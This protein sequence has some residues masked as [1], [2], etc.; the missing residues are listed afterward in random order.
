MRKIVFLLL[1]SFN[2]IG[3]S[4]CLQKVVLTRSK[5]LSNEIIR[6]EEKR[7]NTKPFKYGIGILC[8]RVTKINEIRGFIGIRFEIGLNT[9]FHIEGGLE[10]GMGRN[11]WYGVVTLKPDRRYVFTV[12]PG[13]GFGGPEGFILLIGAEIFIV[14]NISFKFEGRI[15]FFPP[16][17]YGASLLGFGFTYFFE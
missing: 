1:I 5:F 14:N 15:S 4:N 12:Y 7:L 11:Y 2:L 17:P 9:M 6:K 13:M 16:E 3:W 10:R 8:G